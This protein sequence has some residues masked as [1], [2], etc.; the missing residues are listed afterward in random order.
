MCFKIL[1]F[2]FWL[3]W[4]FIPYGR[5]PVGVAGA[6]LCCGA[7]LLITVA[8]LVAESTGSVAHRLQLLHMDLVA[9]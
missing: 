1:F 9:P 8:P 2:Y 3:C 6:T 4:I 5:S 7:W